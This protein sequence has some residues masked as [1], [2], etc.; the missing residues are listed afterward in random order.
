M[1]STFQNATRGSIRN[2]SC[3]K[4]VKIIVGDLRC[5][6][7]LVDTWFSDAKIDLSECVCLPDKNKGGRP[8]GF[9]KMFDMDNSERG[10]FNRM[11]NKLKEKLDINKVQDYEYVRQW[12]REVRGIE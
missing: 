11:Q 9:P 12:I 4:K 2:H 10:K 3:N 6:E 1:E 8:I 5:A 7:Y